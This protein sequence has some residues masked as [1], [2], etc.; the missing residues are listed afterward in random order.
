MAHHSSGPRRAAGR[1]TRML[2]AL[3]AALGIDMYSYRDKVVLIT[4]G[5]RGLGLVM[6][7]RLA[8]AGARLA[9]LARD[10]Q[11]L[12]RARDD[13]RQR[14]AEVLTIKC[15]VRERTQVQ[16]AVRQVVAELG[17]VDVLINNAGTITVGPME[18]MT[19][20]DYED[21][22][23]THFWGPLHAS[24]AVIPE[25]RRRGS[26]RIINISSIGGRMA[27]PH[28]LPYSAG[29]FALTGLSEGMRAEL[30]KDGIVVTTVTPGL[31]RTGSP[32][33][34]FFKGQHRKEF[35]WFTITNS[36]PLISIS[37]EKAA[38][39]I[40]R[41]AGRGRAVVVPSMVAKLAIKI[42]ALM[43]RLS[44]A[45]MA[46]VNRLLP[47]PGGIGTR[48]ARGRD[49]QSRLTS[50]LLT[51]LTQRAA[52]DNNQLGPEQAEGP[53]GQ[54]GAGQAGPSGATE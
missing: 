53:T 27:V 54:Q 28:L 33:N 10:E 17:Q 13:L 43:P 2:T 52:R 37:A 39:I 16:A 35:A 24:L 34:A 20:E 49:S 12:A 3:R 7:R 9:I 42:H 21:S 25:M 1:G 18:V 19:Q 51:I 48:R 26:G 46:L 4:G 40:L 50:S 41:G 32:Y 31:M 23:R 15:D 44:A 47:E 38:R 45:R 8:R 14:G 22:I 29:K 6:A 30:L 36:L 5:S 11:A